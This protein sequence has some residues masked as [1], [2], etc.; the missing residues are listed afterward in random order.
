MKTGD[1]IAIL[2]IKGAQLVRIIGFQEGTGMMVI[3]DGT[4]DFDAVRFHDLGEAS[5]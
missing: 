3:D 2:G 4:D 5:E 1:I